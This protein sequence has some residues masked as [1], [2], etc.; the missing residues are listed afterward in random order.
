MERMNILLIT[1]DQQRWDMLGRTHPVLRTPNLDRLAADGVAFDRAYTVNPVCTPSRC[2]ILT[3]QYPSRH[4]CRH[5]GTALP[6][7]YPTLAGR[8]AEAGY[9][10]AL[11]GKA[12]FRP[13]LDEASFESAPHIHDLDFFRRW[14]GPYH[15]FEHA[16]LVIGHTCEPHA[17]GM[18][19]GA[20]LAEKGVDLKQYF[21]IHD[22]Q[23]FGPW[24]LPEQYH[25]AT[26]TADQT[27]SAI[28]RAGE[29]GKPFFCWASFQDPHNPYIAPEPWASMYRSQDMPL[30]FRAE[31]EGAGKPPFY[32]TL[33]RGEFY[34]DDPE[35]RPNGVGDIKP[36][37]HLKDDDIRRLYAVIC[38]MIGLMDKNI[39]RLLDALEQR[40]L[41]DNTLIIFTTDHGDCL[42]A[43]GLWGKGL[44]AYEDVQRIPFLV[45]HP[46]CET[47]G[48]TSDALQSLV[49][50]EASV[51]SAAGLAPPPGSQGVDQTPAWRDADQRVR[52]W[53]MLEFRPADS[54]FMQRTFVTDEH[55]LVLY[56]GR[57]YGEL[58]NLKND[59]HQ[60]RNLFDEPE[61]CGLRDSLIRRL[62]DAEMDKDGVP[63][64]RTA[65][66]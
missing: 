64:K 35:L 51:L 24:S 10:T 63:Q 20:W 30:P 5:V 60:Q 59:P 1:G 26:W 44:P 14:S 2:T 48:R 37:P 56:R 3:G 8:L 12:H 34:G 61:H 29:V 41:M 33:P 49:D 52:D 40:G 58:Y 21:G 36:L 62:A 31:D 22:Y 6:D 38:G 54:P 47:P 11:L 17:C 45:R 39:G 27:I 66:A 18:H 53:A 23:H 42:G 9:F 15:G 46:R 16:R 57:S 25:A 43:H 50:I 19:Y 7:D 65:Y 55:K 4:G 32:E 13:C 28:D